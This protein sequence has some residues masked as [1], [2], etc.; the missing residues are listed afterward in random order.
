[1]VGVV[2]RQSGSGM[3]RKSMTTDR[4]ISS[5]WRNVKQECLEPSNWAVKM[6]ELVKRIRNCENFSY[7]CKGQD[8]S[9]EECAWK[10]GQHSLRQSGK[11]S[12]KV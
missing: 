8:T 11:Q 9:E 5:G 6:E 3:F 7:G 10:E 1:M 12:T 4:M 2:L